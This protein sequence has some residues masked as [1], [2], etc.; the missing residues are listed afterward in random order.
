MLT[1]REAAQRLGL[2]TTGAVRQLI[3]ADRLKAQKLGRDWFIEEAEIER[4]EN[5]HRSP[6]RP[7]K[8]P[9]DSGIDSGERNA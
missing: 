7:K 5:I 9:I 4:F 3:L 2:K 8:K 6:G 1:T